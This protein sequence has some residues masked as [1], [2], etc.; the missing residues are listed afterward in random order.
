MIA[1]SVKQLFSS[2]LSPLTI[3][4]LLRRRSKQTTQLNLDNHKHG[5]D[6]FSFYDPLPARSVFHFCSETFL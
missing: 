1:A 6:H 5:W 4:R 3:T 2:L